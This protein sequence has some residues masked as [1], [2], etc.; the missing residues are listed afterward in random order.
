ME[1]SRYIRVLKGLHG[2]HVYA[3]EYWTEYL[4]SHAADF[5][6]ADDKSELLVLAKDLA[7]K[8]D[9]AV[10]FAPGEESR[11]DEKPI[12]DWLELLY[13]YPILQ[14]QIRI[15]YQARSLNRL[16]S[17]LYSESGQLY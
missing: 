10:E 7:Q 8:L 6:S 16:E 17:E 1:Q 11:G 14:K 13:P 4:L 15:A 3:S 12:D 2:F 5:G 9:Q